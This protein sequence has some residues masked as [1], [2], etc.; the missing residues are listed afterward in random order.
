MR[1][2]SHVE[3]SNGTKSANKQRIVQI[4]V[5]THDFQNRE[6]YEFGNYGYGKNHVKLLYVNRDGTHHNIREYE[7]DT[8]LKLKT[9]YDY[10]HGN[11]RDIIATDS[12][13]NTV[14]VLAKKHGVKTP[15]EF[16]ILVCSHFLYLYEKVDEV[17][18]KIEEYPWERLQADDRAHNHAFIYSPTATRFCTV[19]QK[20]NESPL[21]KGGLKDLRVLKTTQSA[22]TDFIQDGYRTLPDMNDRVFSTVVAAIWQFSTAN[23]VDFDGA[24]NAVKNCILDKFAGPPETGIFSPSV[25]NTL[26]LAE[27]MVLDKVKQICRIE[28]TM[29]NKHYFSV[30]MSK[31]PKSVLEDNENKEVYLPVDKPSGIIYAELLRKDITAKL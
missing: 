27:K 8:H 26:Y 19:T 4:P 16:G 11:N 18:V 12:Q 23:G 15:E 13:K 2:W 28:M 1:Q 21:I 10:L 24:W 3:K 14:Y 31:F 20:R 22:F 5:G 6:D 25:Q 7:V 9:Q 30:D 17:S 29:P